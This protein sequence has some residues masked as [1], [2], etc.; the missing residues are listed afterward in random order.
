MTLARP[1][2]WRNHGEARRVSGHGWQHQDRDP[3][4]I[5]GEAHGQLGRAGVGSQSAAL[6]LSSPP[7]RITIR[8]KRQADPTHVTIQ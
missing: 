4:P 5:D 2:S 6:S 8:G 1:I 3:E 7:R